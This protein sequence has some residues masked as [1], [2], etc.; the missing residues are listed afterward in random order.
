VTLTVVGR[1]PGPA[2]KELERSNPQIK[3]TGFV[4]DI[5]PYVSRA[6][7]C[8]VPVRIGGGTRLKIYE[9]MAMAKPVVSTSVGAEGLPVRDNEDLLIADGPDEF[10]RAVVRVLTDSALAKRLSRR[11]RALV[12]ERFGW[13]HAAARF[14]EVCELAAGQKSRLRAA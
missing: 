3:I 7:A 4:E 6:A 13:E 2:L 5:R 9:A 14:A 11:A 1:N 12:C 10:A 8:I